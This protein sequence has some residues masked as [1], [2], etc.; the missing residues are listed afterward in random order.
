MFVA[1]IVNDYSKTI[2][3][4]SK[5]GNRLRATVNRISSLPFLIPASAPS[6]RHRFISLDSFLS[7]I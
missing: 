6:I 2:S 5:N 4:S 3:A 7:T 1:L